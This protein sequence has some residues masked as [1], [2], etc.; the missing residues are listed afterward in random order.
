MKALGI[1]GGIAP[2]S[3]VIYYQAIIHHYR[4]E[5]PDGT[6]P[7]ILINSVDLTRLL[8]FVEQK[9]LDGLTEFLLEEIDKLIRAGADL[10]LLASNTP[11]IVFDELEKRSPIPLINITKAGAD[12]A[13]KLGLRRLGLFGTR[14]IMQADVYPRAFK[15]QGMEVVP[16]NRSEQNYIHDTYMTELVHGVEWSATRGL[17]T[18]IAGDMKRRSGIDG[19]I[20]GGCE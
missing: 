9:D 2:A 20:L 13:K 11:H 18:K 14:F 19:M 5:N 7:L 17:F 3:T 10:A 1:I 15:A 8:S 12:A 6:Y 16:P 4:R